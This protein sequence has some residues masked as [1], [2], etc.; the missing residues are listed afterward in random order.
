MRASRWNNL[1]TLYLG[2]DLLLRAE[3]WCVYVTSIN[4]GTQILTFPGIDGIHDFH[5]YR[6]FIEA[7][8]VYNSKR[9]LFALTD[10]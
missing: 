3:I 2:V 6:F 8:I 5:D 7:E 10:K 9:L 1:F 4:D